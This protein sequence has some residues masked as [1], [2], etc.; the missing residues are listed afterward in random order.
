MW[1]NGLLTGKDRL[2]QDRSIKSFKASG[3]G[4][5]IH[6]CGDGI[7]LVARFIAPHSVFVW[8]FQSYDCWYSYTHVDDCMSCDRY[9]LH[10][11]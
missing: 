5:S 2:V 8:A 11:R 10:S 1:K 9:H 4:L 6:D 7:P 3:E